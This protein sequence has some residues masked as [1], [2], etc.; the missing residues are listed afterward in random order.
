MNS[1]HRND[2]APRVRSLVLAVLTIL[3]IITHLFWLPISAH[4]GQ[5]AI[6]W[7]LN[8]GMTLFGDVYEQ[9]APATT[10]IAAFASRVTSLNAI[11]T[12]RILNVLLVVAI[13]FLVYG[14]ASRLSHLRTSAGL[15]AA[16]TWVV[17]E[18]SFGNILFYFDGVMSLLIIAALLL[19]LWGQKQGKRVFIAW[20]AGLL[21]G[22]STLAKQQAWAAVVVF[23]I[24]IVIF[25]RQYF[26][27]YSV[28][29][30]FMPVLVVLVVGLQG[31]LDSY[32]YWNWA[33]NVSGLMPNALPAS[34]FAIKL[35]ISNAM[36]LPC[37][38]LSLRQ[39]E[40]PLWILALILWLGSTATLIPRFNQIH[41]LGH[42]G[43]TAVLSGC[44]IGVFVDMFQ[45]N[46]M[47]MAGVLRE[48]RLSQL[49]LIALTITLAFIWLVVSLLP[50]VPASQAIGRIPAYQEFTSI[51]HLL[52]ERSQPGD[53]LFVLPETDSTPQIHVLSE[54]IAPGTWVKGWSWYLT[55]DMVDQLLTEWAAN[56]PTWI[57]VFPEM[58][59]EGM[60][61]IEALLEFTE[62]NYIAEFDVDQVQDHGS[63]LIY[64][65]A[66]GNASHS[67]ASRA[68]RRS[69]R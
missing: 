40:R 32:L 13:M 23:G 12:A 62:S 43:L 28:G 39:T 47:T 29:A 10:L 55:S 48:T 35:L 36:V 30:L 67:P 17:W 20:G 21:M 60:P 16:V 49:M 26:G 34:G 19:W 7:M 45:R 51:S 42:L 18:P 53:T 46:R 22:A 65:L 54:M 6:P 33:F 37:V 64:R 14:T 66:D 44:V 56:P 4:S 57:V 61:G 58:I 27:W 15:G 63:A 2:L 3:Q 25:A 31:N 52:R 59:G 50:Y 1:L 8:Q 5:V 68:S 24:W 41:A 38:L 69:A 9:H 11:N